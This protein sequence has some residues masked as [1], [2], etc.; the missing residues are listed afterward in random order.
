M[1][2]EFCGVDWARVAYITTCDRP[3]ATR[4]RLHTTKE[5]AIARFLA[6][7]GDVKLIR[8]NLDTLEIEDVT[9]GHPIGYSD[10]HIQESR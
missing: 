9:P 4:A 10:E 3:G 1:K 6:R 2:C 8:L 5:T 7:D